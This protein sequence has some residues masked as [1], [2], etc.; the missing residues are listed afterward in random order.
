MLQQL[1]NNCSGWEGPPLERFMEDC[2]PQLWLHAGAGKG[3][4][5]EGAAEKLLYSVYNPHS[6]SF[7]TALGQGRESL[8]RKGGGRSFN[9][10]FVFFYLAIK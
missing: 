10:W 2:I 9:L 4:E 8:G 5:K 6:P 3:C 1:I 7:S